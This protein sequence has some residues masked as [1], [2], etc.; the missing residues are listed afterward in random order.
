MFP[1]WGGLMAEYGMEGI[2]REDRFYSIQRVCTDG[3][4]DYAA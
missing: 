2:S 4:S 3:S 1:R